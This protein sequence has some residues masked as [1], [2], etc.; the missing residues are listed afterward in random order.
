[1]GSPTTNNPTIVSQV[2]RGIPAIALG[3]TLR[4]GLRV[5]SQRWRRW[6]AIT[7]DTR[8]AH[9]LRARFVVGTPVSLIAIRMV[10][11]CYRTRS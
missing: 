8:S 11:R 6:S 2:L 7:A 10:N 5:N 3:P 4:P 1:M 9:S